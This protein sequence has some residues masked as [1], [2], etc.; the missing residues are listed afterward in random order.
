MK[1]I[2]I[3]ILFS[4]ISL[5]SWSKPKLPEEVKPIYHLI[6]SGQVELTS[7]EIVN[8]YK[9]IKSPEFMIDTHALLGLFTP[10]EL[11]QEGLNAVDIVE[12]KE[13]HNIKNYQSYF[14]Y[15]VGWAIDRT[16]HQTESYHNYKWIDKPRPKKPDN[17]D[18][19]LQ[20]LLK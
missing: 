4:L 19:K 9:E 8:I 5:Y 3:T 15:T 11:Y 2:I 18:I 14:I 16:I 6:I 20:A 7:G 1:N 12:L 13:T 17:I 10:G